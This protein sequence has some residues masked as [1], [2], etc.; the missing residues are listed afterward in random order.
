M[1]LFS[2][3]LLGWALLLTVLLITLIGLA[4]WFYGVDTRHP[5]VFNNLPFPVDKAVYL[6]GEN[7]V[8]TV[9]G[10]VNASRP[11]ITAIEVRG[12]EKAG[13]RKNYVLPARY[14]PA[15]PTTGCFK[16][17][18]PTALPGDILPGTYHFEAD[19]T[20]QVNRFA[21]RTVHWSTAPFEVRP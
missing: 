13:V 12:E 11:S 3:L 2:R 15:S 20:F 8:S 21:K 9:D 14:A 5:I 10:C 19:R 1:K 18:I 6:P 4:T 17:Q 7:V 16:V